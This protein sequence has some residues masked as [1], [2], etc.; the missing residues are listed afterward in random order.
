[1]W[2][3]YQSVIP[4]EQH[5]PVEKSSGETNHLE[6]WNLTLRQRLGRFVTRTLSFSKCNHTHEICLRLF[7]REYN[8]SRARDPLYQPRVGHYLAALSAAGAE[9]LVVGAHALAVH[10]RPRATGD[11]DIWVHSTPENA[12]R[13]WHALEEFGAPLQPA[14]ARRSLLAGHRLPDLHDAMTPFEYLLFAYL[15]LAM[16]RFYQQ[17]RARTG[18]KMFGLLAG[19]LATL[20]LLEMAIS[21]AAQLTGW[22]G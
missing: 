1:F 6:R 13:V 20:V 15:F 7:L 3:A 12:P 11:L 4:E 18:L 14:H 10:G 16:G 9:H 2:Q 22:M 17:P 5:A 8:R 19:Y 21:R